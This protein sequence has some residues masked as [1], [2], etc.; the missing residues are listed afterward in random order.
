MALGIDRASIPPLRLVDNVP[1]SLVREVLAIHK[2]V[3]LI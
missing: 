1:S 3:T 2:G